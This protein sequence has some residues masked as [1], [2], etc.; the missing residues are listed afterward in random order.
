MAAGDDIRKVSASSAKENR[1]R[2]KLDRRLKPRRQE[3]G[4]QA[5]K[6]IEER[7]QLS[8]RR[9]GGKIIGIV[10]VVQ[11]AAKIRRHQRRAK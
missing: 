6:K 5:E 2:R 4:K 11:L 10:S 8:W 9:K 7:R 1:K 3:I